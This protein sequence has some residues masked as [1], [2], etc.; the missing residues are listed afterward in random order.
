MNPQCSGLLVAVASYIVRQLCDIPQI[1]MNV[2]VIMEDVTTSV[3]TLR[4][5]LSVRATFLT[6]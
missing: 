2:S 5:H 3:Q 1:S 6:Y 4:A